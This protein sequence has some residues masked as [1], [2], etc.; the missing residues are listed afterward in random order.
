MLELCLLHMPCNQPKDAGVA[1]PAAHAVQP[2]DAGVAVPAA[3]AVQPKA[4]AVPIGQI[5]E[6]K[7]AAGVPA[8][9]HVPPLKAAPVPKAPGSPPR[10]APV[11]IPQ[12]VAAKAVPARA[13]P[14][15]LQPVPGMLQIP[16][17]APQPPPAKAGVALPE[18]TPADVD[19]PRDDALSR[20][21]RLQCRLR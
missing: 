3:H 5:A 7:D 4:G 16:L 10:H 11:A 13:A 21:R 15:L 2:T 20:C 18:N 8:K 14:D 9:A 12:Q 19:E 6:P 1:V 17:Q